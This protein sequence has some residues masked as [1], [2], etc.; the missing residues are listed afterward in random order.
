MDLKTGK[1]KFSYLIENKNNKYN[2]TVFI[3]EIN[4]QLVIAGNYYKYDKN[5]EYDMTDNLGF[6]KIVLNEEGKEIS[7][8]Y[9]GWNNFKNFGIESDGKIDKNYRLSTK[10]LFIFK[11]GSIGILTEKLSPSRK[12]IGRFI[13]LPIIDDIADVTTKK[14][15]ETSDL[16]LFSF[17]NNFT[18]QKIHTIKKEYSKGYS[19]DYLYSQYIKNDTGIVFFFQD[20]NN[21]KKDRNKWTLGIN[22]FINGELKEEKIPMASSKE[23]YDIT[24]IYAKEGYILLYEQNKKDK[25]NQLRL[26]KLNY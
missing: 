18:S 11:D 4:D 22:T 9:S 14:R 10:D 25:Y 21:D 3:K 2:H 16:V 1:E 5:Q 6:Y 8:S 20:K 12:G 13:P 17:D 23:G 7:K 26:E 15:E 24:P 19:H